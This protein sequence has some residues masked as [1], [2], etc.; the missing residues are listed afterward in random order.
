MLWKSAELLPPLIDDIMFKV[1]YK[2]S[3]MKGDPYV[4]VEGN[5]G[6]LATQG[7]RV[8]VAGK[9]YLGFFHATGRLV[10]AMKNL[11]RNL[12]S[13]VDEESHCIAEGADFLYN[14]EWEAAQPVLSH[15]VEEPA[16]FAEPPEGRAKRSAGI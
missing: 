3:E 10:A 5:L 2:P 9:C 7:G 4:L 11:G 6:K 15:F 8:A 16:K 14:S 1:D 13:V 12:R